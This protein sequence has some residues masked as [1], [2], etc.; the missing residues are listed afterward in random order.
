MLAYFVVSNI[1]LLSTGIAFSAY[2]PAT[3]CV[4]QMFTHSHLSR[5][6]ASELFNIRLELLRSLQRRKMS[7]RIMKPIEH[8]IRPLSRPAFGCSRHPI[9]AQIQPHQLLYGRDREL[10]RAC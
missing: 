10:L 4:Q 7:T 9:S 5:L 3:P 6:P 1:V 8:Q 2:E